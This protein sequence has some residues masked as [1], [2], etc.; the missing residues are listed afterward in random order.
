MGAPLTLADRLALALSR[1]V[2]IAEG[3]VIVPEGMAEPVREV[4]RREAEVAEK[5]LA[6]WR[7]ERGEP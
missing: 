5:A 7:R 3:I 1:L 6:E 2:G 4:L